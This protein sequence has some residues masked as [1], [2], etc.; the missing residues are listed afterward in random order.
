[1]LGSLTRYFKFYLGGGGLA[2]IK[3]KRPKQHVATTMTRRRG[4]YF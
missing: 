4:R 1:M 3:F 2:R